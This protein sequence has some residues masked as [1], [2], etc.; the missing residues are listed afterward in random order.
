MTILKMA[1]EQLI[2]KQQSEIDHLKT[3]IVTLRSDNEDLKVDREKL[4]EGKFICTY[5]FGIIASVL[6][7]SI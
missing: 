5:N 4:A 7:E 1:N 3:T 6:L 2:S